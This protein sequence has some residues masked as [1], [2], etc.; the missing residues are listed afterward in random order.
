MAERNALLKEPL[1]GPLS[2][3]RAAEIALAHPNAALMQRME[4]PSFR[5]IRR[6]TNLLLKVKRQAR[7]GESRE[8]PPR[9]RE[10]YERKAG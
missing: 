7:K 9:T 4:E 5:Q 8:T 3:E 2:Y 6:I 10:V 1:A